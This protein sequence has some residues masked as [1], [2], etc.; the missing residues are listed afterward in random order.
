MNKQEYR[1]WL[2]ERS[3]TYQQSKS[4]LLMEVREAAAVQRK[5]VDALHL[6]QRARFLDKREEEAALK[7]D[8]Y[9]WRMIRE[10]HAVRTRREKAE[11]RRQQDI[12]RRRK[13]YWKARKAANRREKARIR[14]EA[15]HL[16]SME[17][18]RKEA[19]RLDKVLAYAPEWAFDLIGR[20][21]RFQKSGQSAYGVQRGIAERLVIHHGT[22]LVSIRVGHQGKRKR[23][24]YVSLNKVL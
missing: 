18:R 9:C 3:R 23:N 5:R 14:M 12:I 19:I 4:L 22:V 10:F 17:A 21:V 6:R 24:I 20:E 1:E 8:A 15:M 7:A 16:R 13:A 11:A 2:R